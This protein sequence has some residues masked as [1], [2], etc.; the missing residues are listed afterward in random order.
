MRPF[1]SVALSLSLLLALTSCN[2]GMSSVGSSND[3]PVG[4]TESAAEGPPKLTNGRVQRAVDRALDW[5]QKGGR[6]I[7]LGIQELPQENAARADIRFDGFQYNSDPEE[8]QFPRT[9]N[10]LRS[11]M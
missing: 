3:Q 1:E 5:T 7:V 11:L 6:A 9:K 2:K 10:H 4:V 8:H